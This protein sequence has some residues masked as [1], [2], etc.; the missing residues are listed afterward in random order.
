LVRSE[1]RFYHLGLM[2]YMG[3]RRS[4]GVGASFTLS[5]LSLTNISIFFVYTHLSRVGVWTGYPYTLDIEI[6]RLNSNRLNKNHSNHTNN[7]LAL[8]VF[9]I[10]KPGVTTSPIARNGSRLL[11]PHTEDCDRRPSFELWQ[12]AHVLRTP[13]S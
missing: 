11:F 6:L 13:H 3:F 7:L 1:R 4:L 8:I 2:L 12:C 10:G 9:D 5:C